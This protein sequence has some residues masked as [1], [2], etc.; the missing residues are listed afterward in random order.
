[1]DVLELK[2]GNWMVVAWDPGL[3]S[4][5]GRVSANTGEVNLCKHLRPCY[6]IMAPTKSSCVNKVG[7]FFK[8]KR[9]D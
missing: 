4:G 6:Q 8:G 2:L 1:M 5:P 3:V 9:P 7:L